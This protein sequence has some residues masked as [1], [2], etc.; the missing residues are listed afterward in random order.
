MRYLFA[1]TFIFTVIF[2]TAQERVRINLDEYKKEKE[3]TYVDKKNIIKLDLT[4]LMLGKQR[5]GY[6]R[7]VHPLMSVQGSVGITFRPLTP[8]RDNYFGTEEVYS[9]H[10]YFFTCQHNLDD[11][12]I[13]VFKPGF[14]SSLGWKIYFDKEYPLC[15]PYFSLE[16]SYSIFINDITVRA[17]SSGLLSDQVLTEKYRFKDIS[18]MFGY[19]YLTDFLSVEFSGGAGIRFQDADYVLLGWDSQFESQNTIVNGKKT[20]PI[21]RMEAKFGFRF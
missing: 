15:G 8:T 12:N 20:Y 21:I 7:L 6:Q 16:T 18:G 13:R 1:V 2:L 17:R 5:I 10:C 4:S 11:Y 14:T 19:Q 9:Y 3:K